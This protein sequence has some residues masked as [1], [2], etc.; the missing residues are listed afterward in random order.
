MFL[1]SKIP[2]I[3]LKLMDFI[4]DQKYILEVRPWLKSGG[5]PRLGESGG[6]GPG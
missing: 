2:L 5:R 4:N 6:I 3:L 1:N